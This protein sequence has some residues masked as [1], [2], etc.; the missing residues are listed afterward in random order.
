MRYAEK[1][2]ALLSK[3][4]DQLV[5]PAQRKAD[6]LAQI[7][8]RDTGP[9]TQDQ[10]RPLL[11]LFVGR[12]CGD[13]VRPGDLFA[14]D[15]LAAL[16]RY[17]W[18]GNVRELENVIERAVILADGGQIDAE[19]I[20]IETGLMPGTCAAAA[21]TRA[22]NAIIISAMVEKQLNNAKE[23]AGADAD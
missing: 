18:P 10:A 16:R 5:G 13:G 14:E 6:L 2:Q 1:G 15:V 20:H 23:N 17:P 8:D 7:A 3:A 11:E 21:A 19:D 12:A 9:P 4:L 22:A